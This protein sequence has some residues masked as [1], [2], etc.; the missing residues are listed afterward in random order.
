MKQPK[1]QPKSER[2]ASGSRPAR[3]SLIEFAAPAAGNSAILLSPTPGLPRARFPGVLPPNGRPHAAPDPAARA[4][5]E[6]D[7][8][9]RDTAEDR[10][11][12]ADDDVPF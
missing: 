1:S 4:P 3:R 5:D 9:M 12:R 10:P 8:E 7:E 6:P 11:A 2:R